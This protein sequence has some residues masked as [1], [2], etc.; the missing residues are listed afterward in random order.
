MYAL[1]IL[2][3]AEREISK[4][5]WTD[6]EKLKAAIA[7]LAEDPRPVNCRKL[8]GRE[9]WRIRVGS[10]RVLYEIDDTTRVVTVVGIGHRRDVYR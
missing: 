5:H 4:I 1:L 10:Y 8:K 7:A 9:A 2:P 3:R 6:F